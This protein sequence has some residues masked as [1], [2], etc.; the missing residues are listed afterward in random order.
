MIIIQTS[1][2]R[3]KS[4]AFSM[5]ETKIKLNKHLRYQIQLKVVL[6][7]TSISTIKVQSIFYEKNENR[8]KHLRCQ[9]TAKKYP[10]LNK[11]KYNSR[12]VELKI[13]LYH[14]CIIHT[15]NTVKVLHNFPLSSNHK[16]TYKIRHIQ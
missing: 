12:A 1:L 6:I 3:I 5:Q 11:P 4:K 9:I 10:N 2:S 15:L 8:A 13:E 7:Q 14:F 16:H